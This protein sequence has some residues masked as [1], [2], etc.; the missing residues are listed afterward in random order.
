[1]RDIG[2]GSFV[3]RL[4]LVREYV[5]GTK[6]TAPSA[7]TELFTRLLSGRRM[8]AVIGP[9]GVDTSLQ[10]MLARNKV[11]WFTPAGGTTTLSAVGI[12]ITATGTATAKTMAATSLY[13]SI[14]GIEYLV[15]TAATT[16]V[17]GFRA[18]AISYWRGNA[19]NRGGFHMITRWGPATGVATATYRAFCGMQSSTSAPTDVEP[20]SLINMMGM[21][22]DA[23]D[24]QVQWMVND[25]T[26]TA[27][28]T[29]LGA[30]FVVPTA[31]RPT[32][33]EISIWC[34]PN[35]SAINYEVTDLTTGAVASGSS[36]TDIPS[37]TTFLA[38]R[39]YCSVG[40]TSAVVGF[41]LFSGYVETDT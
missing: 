1:M 40:G 20:S 16:A 3:Q 36:T 13:T 10:P 19:A 18:S 2:P 37:N 35:G 9:A 23:A 25:G 29:A 11:A 24:A 22:W 33:Y 31:D 12:A 15:T 8:P 32:V 34:P 30:S 5:G 4:H 17:A 6:P 28:K 39:G 27:T 38:P 14:N 41:G 21:G 26:G 7:G